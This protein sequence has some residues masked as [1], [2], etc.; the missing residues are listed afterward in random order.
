MDLKK[1]LLKAFVTIGALKLLSIPV[2]LLT[3]V[4]LARTLEPEGY[5]KYI[6]VITL[7]TLIALPIT[8][9]LSQFITREVALYRVDEKWELYKGLLKSAFLYVIVFSFFLIFISHFSLHLISPWEQNERV[10]LF[11]IGILLIPILGLSAI[12][13]GVIKGFEKPVYSE[14][15]NIVIKPILA[16][17]FISLLLSYEKL[18]IENALWS[19]VL[20]TLLSFMLTTWFYY[21]IQPKGIKKYS[22][23]YD[24][25]P[26]LVALL[27]FSLLA[28]VTTFN[29][30]LSI[31]LLGTLHSD[32]QVA[33]MN[34]AEKFAQFVLLS[35]TIVNMVIAPYIVKL[36][37]QNSFKELQAL[38]KKSSQLAL[39]VAFPVGLIFILYSK[40]IIY[41]FFGVS[42]VEISETP[43]IIM[44]TGQLINVFF[45]SVGYF[46]TM[47]G[48]ENQA[49]KGLLAALLTNFLMSLVLV[50]SYGATGAAF[51]VAVSIFVWNFLL[52][53][54]VQAK[55]GIK[56]RAI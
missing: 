35:L 33:A 29:S 52:Y 40:E 34:I 2:A 32:V 16:L 37:K 12:R 49:L 15:P 11:L 53:K 43:V 3:T 47:S 55:L 54:Y 41:Y 44:V 51:S 9:G 14:L 56:V 1:V 24:F 50:P 48:H 42:Y 6:F 13:S 23:E 28:L 46:L 30:K 5:G 38:A 10:D 36:Y 7:V 27:P 45:G 4:I 39:I 26:W 20:A 19:Q 8:G 18:T 31:L 25:K 22:Y 21:T 17:I